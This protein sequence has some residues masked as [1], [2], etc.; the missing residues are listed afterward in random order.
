[1]AVFAAA[2]EGPPSS[3]GRLVQAAIEQFSAKW[4][5][6]VSV[7]EI[8]RAAGLSNGLFYRYFQSKEEI[9]QAYPGV[10]DKP[11]SGSPEIDSGHWEQGS[12]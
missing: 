9:F 2:Q 5:G 3:K 8:C 6:T 1:M 4:Y 10:R 11:H 12:D 7:A